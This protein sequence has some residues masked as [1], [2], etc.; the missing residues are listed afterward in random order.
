[1]LTRREALAQV[2]LLDEGYFMYSEEVDWARRF[3]RAGWRVVYLP[4]AEIV[5]YEGR[6]SEQVVPQRH[7]YFQTSKVRYVRQWHGPLTAEILR[8]FLLATYVYQLVEEGAKWLLGHKRPLRA[9]RV[10]AYRRVLRS[11]LR[12]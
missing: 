9:E 12:A 11:G 3:K 2:G 5:H 6:S 10:R 8:L 7:I 4:T 1:M